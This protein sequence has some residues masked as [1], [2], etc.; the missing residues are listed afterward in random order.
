MKFIN[1][2]DFDSLTE[3]LTN[4]KHGIFSVNGKL[5]LYSCEKLPANE[6]PSYSPISFS[7]PSV[8]PSTV[9]RQLSDIVTTRRPRASSID[10]SP[11]RRIRPRGGSLGSLDEIGS[12]TLLSQMREALNQ[13]FPDYDFSAM[14]YE[15]FISLSLKECMHTVNNHLAFLKVRFPSSQIF[16]PVYF[17]IEAIKYVHRSKIVNFCTSCGNL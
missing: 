11:I 1:H 4:R 16:F 10:L 2:L 15:Q 7:Y 14:K 8:D 13:C 17:L 6:S 3:F 5:E 9:T 12:Q